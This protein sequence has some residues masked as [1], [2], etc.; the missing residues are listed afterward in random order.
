M[1]V[2]KGDG[3]GAV[4]QNNRKKAVPCDWTGTLENPMKCLWRGELDRMSKFFSPPVHL[5]AVT[6]ITEMSLH[7]TLSNNLTH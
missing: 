6:Y 2:V 4:S 3:N 1:R 7:L 5:F